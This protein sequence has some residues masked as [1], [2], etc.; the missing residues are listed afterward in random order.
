LHRGPSGVAVAL[1][2]VVD[3]LLARVDVSSR[4]PTSC[5]RSANF[6]PRL[7]SIS[8]SPKAHRTKSTS[9]SVPCATSPGRA[10]KGVCSTFLADR[11]VPGGT[12]V[13]VFVHPNKASVRRERRT[14]MIM[15][16]PGTG[17]APFRAF[18]ESARDRRA[19]KKR[20]CFGDQ[21]AATDFLYATNCS[22]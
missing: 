16:G 21:R 13:G 18:L 15:V 12:R 19:R 5:A 9:P 4:P 20:L 6:K 17:I 2:H 7:Y 22:R 3:V 8:S 11:V 10:R 1:H 14:P